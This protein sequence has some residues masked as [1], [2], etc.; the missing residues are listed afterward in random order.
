M[1]QQSG[2]EQDLERLAN[3][4][5]GDRCQAFDETFGD[6]GGLEDF[7]GGSLVSDVDSGR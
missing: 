5:T 4:E 2:T 7:S 6:E 3:A 1:L